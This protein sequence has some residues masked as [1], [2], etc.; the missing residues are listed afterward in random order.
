MFMAKATKNKSKRNSKLRGN[1]GK[2]YKNV[3]INI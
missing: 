3:S 1:I 2:K